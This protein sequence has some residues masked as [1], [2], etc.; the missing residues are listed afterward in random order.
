MTP[1][2][3]HDVVSEML[4]A[5]K[6]GTL[7]GSIS[8]KGHFSRPSA[9]WKL[10]HF[11][12]WKWKRRW[13]LRLPWSRGSHI[14]IPGGWEI[15]LVLPLHPTHSDLTGTKVGHWCFFK[16]P[17]P[18][19]IL[20]SS[21]GWKAENPRDSA[22]F[23]GNTAKCPSLVNTIKEPRSNAYNL[24]PPEH[25]KEPRQRWERHSLSFPPNWAEDKSQGR[26]ARPQ[27]WEG[28]SRGECLPEEQTFSLRLEEEWNLDK[29]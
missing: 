15:T 17:P 2:R 11:W 25:L 16:S 5:Q 7:K 9:A 12:P 21:Q 18:Q 1:F 23:W 28:A 6:I 29:W 4:K 26:Y 13:A 27:W 22:E 10:W 14:R 3:S 8:G 20:T 24:S 19:V